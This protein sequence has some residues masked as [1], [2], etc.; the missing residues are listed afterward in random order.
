MKSK[1]DFV[2]FVVRIHWVI[3]CNEPSEGADSAPAA[4]ALD[5]F[6][7]AVL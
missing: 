4:S 1:G 3:R 2:V 6:G 5:R 7:V